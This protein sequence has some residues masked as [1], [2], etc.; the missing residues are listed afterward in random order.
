MLTSSITRVSMVFS[1]LRVAS[2]WSMSWSAMSPIGSR[3]S[4][5]IVCPPTLSAA[6]PVGAAMTICFSVFQFR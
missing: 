1:S 6:T 3:N 2:F 4:E 5:W